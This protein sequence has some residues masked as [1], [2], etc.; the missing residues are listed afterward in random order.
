MPARFRLRRALVLPIYAVAQI[1]DFASAVL[2]CFAA[3]I[4]RRRWP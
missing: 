4:A 3:R 1:L 2:G